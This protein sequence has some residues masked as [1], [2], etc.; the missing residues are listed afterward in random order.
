MACP[1]DIVKF[2]YII[3]YSAAEVIGHFV[4]LLVKSLFK[5]INLIIVKLFKNIVRKKLGIFT[6]LIIENSISCRNFCSAKMSYG[7][8]CNICEAVFS[9][10]ET[11][12]K[13]YNEV[14]VK[15]QNKQLRK[16]TSTWSRSTHIGLLNTRKCRTWTTLH[17]KS[18]W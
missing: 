5:D 11:P 17:G 8:K 6:K 16:S 1:R 3:H 12:W 18:K 13:H 2:V 15:K 10:M 14:H 7:Y 9:N 4:V